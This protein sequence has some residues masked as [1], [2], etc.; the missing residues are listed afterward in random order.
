MDQR[1]LDIL[2]QLTLEEKAGLCSGADMWNTK[3]V[4]RLGIPSIMVSDGPH[5]LRKQ[6]DGMDNFGLHHSLPATCF[7]TASA[8]GSSWNPS[9]IRE[10]GEAIAQECLTQ[11][12]SVLLGP[13]INIKRNPLCGRNFEY[14]SEDPYLTGEMAT[15]F[16]KG[17][18]SKGI[19]TSIKHFAVNNQENYR[20]TID[21]VVDERALREI[22]LLGFEMA[23]KEAEPWT[24]MCAYN[25]VN[26]T[27]ASENKKLLTDILETEWN[28]DGM[29]MS[30]WGA[31]NDRVEGVQSGLHLEMPG[32]GLDNDKKIVEAVKNGTMSME[33][34]DKAVAKLLQLILNGESNKD[35]KASFDQE[36]H[37]Q[38]A[39]KAAKDSAVL[40]K[41]E[42]GILPLTKDKKKYALIGDLAV[43]SRYQGSG[44]SLINPTMI[45]SVYDAFTEKG[46]DFQYAKGYDRIDGKTDL[47]L[48]YEAVEQAKDS[49]V[50]IIVAGLP[51][52][53]E[54][55]G[56]DRDHMK[57]PLNQTELIKEISAVHDNVVIVLVG[58]APVEMPW[59]SEVRG[60]LNLY[61]AGQGIGSA[62]VD[63]L[64]GIHNPSG[65]LAETFGKT[66]EDYPSASYFPEGPATVEY[67]ESIYV[68]YRYFDT[69]KV[70]PLFPFGYG[71]SYTTFRFSNLV[72]SEREID[73]NGTLE[74]SV[75]VTNSGDRPGAEVVQLYV[76]DTTSHVFK[77]EKELKRFQKVF[78]QPGET[79]TCQFELDRRAFSFYNVDMEDWCVIS[80]EYE[81]LIGSSSR[82]IFEQSIVKV[83][84]KEFQMPYEGKNI[85][86][87]LTPPYPFKAQDREFAIV[88]G[89]SL[90]SKATFPGEEFSYDSTL[91][92]ISSTFVGKKVHDAIIKQITRPYREMEDENAVVSKNMMKKMIPN[93]PLRSLAISSNGALTFGMLDGLLL[94][95]NRK[96]IKGTGKL[97]K[98]TIRNKVQ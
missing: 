15:A 79:V 74:V 18:Q 87:F 85:P 76:K 58:G 69:A 22:Y 32:G 84:G 75:N 23:I 57:L 9:L 80:G 97:I 96:R 98:E 83:L 19:G 61:L 17:V 27:Y 38:L 47:D 66:Y 5:G 90:P 11:G 48:V 43:H 24:V 16:I 13:G 30:D 42:N 33:V 2:E 21:A 53:A 28:Y 62:A 73:E 67:R 93:H 7:P 81:I 65:K 20:M 3:S 91:K 1:I 31:V 71:L 78:L 10:V 55:E 92:E 41:N 29:V 51:A 60:L 40:L 56:F 46:I 54:S 50:A 8:L 4:E 94:I 68:G 88:Y 45:D 63:L 89:K 77:A 35:T 39:I 37:H 25:K 72:L 36:S 26:G 49:D 34:L 70:E 6:P 82:D 52:L 14:Y 64:F 12:V 59:I 44:S 86:S 95:L